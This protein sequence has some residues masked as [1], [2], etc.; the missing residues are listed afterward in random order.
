M[1]RMLTAFTEEIDDAEAA[2]SEILGQLALDDNLMENSVGILHCACD[3]DES[4]VVRELCGRLPFD[5]VGCTSVSVQVPG[6]M[7][8]LALVLTVLTSG[9]VKFVSGVSAP[10]SDGLDAP[11]SEMYGRTMG[12][13]SERPALIM[14]FIPLIKGIGGDEF[15]EKIDLLSGGGIPAFGTIASSNELGLS[16]SYTIY[17]GEFYS[18]SL[19]LLGL[20]GDVNPMFFS[21]SVD[22]GNILKQKAVVTEVRKNILKSVNNVPAMTYLESLGLSSSGDVSGFGSMP[23]V[24]KLDDGST[25]IRGCIDSNEDGSLVLGGSIPEGSTFAIAMMG[26]DDVLSSTG[27]AVGEAVEKGGGRGV[28]IYSCVARGWTLGTKVMAEHEEVDRRIAG[29][30]PYCFAYSGGEI[31]PMFLDDGRISNHLQNDTIILCAL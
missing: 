15:I 24:I 14:P 2:I 4:A 29:S 12:S 26:S 7:S 5:V 3:F 27:A 21:A 30:A 8:Q 10:I 18:T 20:I 25:L 31:F 19:V 16:R 6:I 9:D 23:F 28:L 11:V 1:I 17:N 22:D 13:L